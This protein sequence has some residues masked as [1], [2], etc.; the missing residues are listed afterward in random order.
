MS[1]ASS[2]GGA[3]GA[4]GVGIEGRITAWV[5]CHVLARRTVVEFDVAGVPVSVG[6]QTSHG[7]DDVGVVLDDGGYVLIQSKKKLTR[8][9]LDD[10]DLADAL[11]QVVAVFRDGL[12]VGHESS[13]IR[14]VDPVRDRLVILTDQDAPPTVREDMAQVVSRL[15]HLPATEPFDGVA[16]N[17]GQATALRVLLE[18]LR[19]EWS[20]HPA[21]AK[22]KGKTKGVAAPV[23]GS[24]TAAGC[25]HVPG[26]T[27]TDDEL[28]A[29]FRVLRVCAVGLSAGQPERRAA[30]TLAGPLL[31]VP[32]VAPQ[33]FERLAGL[34]QM[35]AEA[36]QWRGRDALKQQLRSWGLELAV[37][38]DVL[39]DVQRLKDL[40]G[41]ALELDSGHI[42][43]PGGSRFHLQRDVVAVL[44]AAAA[45][46]EALAVVG[47]AG[48]GKTA[49]VAQLAQQFRTT[50]GDVVYLTAETLAGTG[51]D[52]RVTLGLNHDLQQVLSGWEGPGHGLLIIDGL[53]GARLAEPSVWLR[54]LVAHLQQSRWH[55]VASMRMFD[56][57]RGRAWQR[58]FPGAAPDLN[59]AVAGLPDVRHVLV[60][61]LNDAEITLA[62]GAHA[63]LAKLVDVTSAAPGFTGLIRNMFNLAIAAD[64]LADPDV[65]IARV[66]GAASQRDLLRAYWQRRVTDYARAG[67]LHQLAARM[68]Q[69]RRLRVPNP[70][71]VVDSAGQKVLE[72][73]LRDGVLRTEP[74]AVGPDPVAFAHT[75][76]FDHAV[77]ELILSDGDDPENLAAVLEQDP[78]LAIVARPS[79]DMHLR[80][81]W[82]ADRSAFFRLALQLATDHPSA[83]AAAA[84]VMVEG[85][86]SEQDLEPL[87]QACL[88]GPAQTTAR[89]FAARQLGAALM[90]PG[91]LAAVGAAAAGPV[92]S[93]AAQLARTARDRDDVGLA[94]VARVLVNRARTAAGDGGPGA[95]DRAE[96][97]LAVMATALA[98]PE[99]G[100]RQSLAASIADALADAAALDPAGVEA[101]VTEICSKQAMAAWGPAVV[102]GLARRVT[103]LAALAP[104]A[105][106]VL[107]ETLWGFRDP[108]PEES[109]PLGRSSILSY[110]STRGGE[111]AMAQF[112]IGVH[113]PELLAADPVFAA[114]IY[115]AAMQAITPTADPWTVPTEPDS[116]DG[117]PTAAPA[118]PQLPQV[119]EGDALEWLGDH[120]TLARMTGQLAD[121]LLLLADPAAPGHD[122]DA[123]TEIINVLTGLRDA[124]AWNVLLDRGSDAPAT[125]GVALAALLPGG[126]LLAHPHTAEAAARLLATVRDLVDDDLHAAIEVQILADRSGFHGPASTQAVAWR[127]GMLLGVLRRDK[128]TDIEARQILDDYDAS[129]HAAPAPTPRGGPGLGARALDPS[130]LP[131]LLGRPTAEPGPADAIDQA[132]S[133]VFDPDPAGAS[134]ARWQLADA[135]TA[136]ADKLGNNIAATVTEDE[137]L[138]QAAVRAAAVLADDAAMAIDTALAER[139][140]TVL[141]A[142][143]GQAAS[144][145]PPPGW[146]LAKTVEGMAALLAIESTPHR[147][148]LSSALEVLS[149]M[150]DGAVQEAAAG[151][152]P[153]RWPDLQTR[154]T[155]VI[156]YL[157][158]TEGDAQAAWLNQLAAI[159]INDPAAGDAA[160][161]DLA[162]GEPWTLLSREPESGSPS[163]S[164]SANRPLR[165]AVELAVW[166]TVAAQQPQASATAKAWLSHPADHPVR[167]ERACV[168]LMDYFKLSGATAP[169]RRALADAFALAALPL[170]AARQA[171]ADYQAQ[172]A[173]PGASE[174][175]R[176]VLDVAVAVARAIHLTS[177][178]STAFTRGGL[179]DRDGQEPTAQ[180][181][182]RLAQDRQV[183]ADLAFPVL[184]QLGG[185][186]HPRV[187]EDTVRTLMHLASADP[188]RA[189]LAA[190]DAI[191]ASP[192]YHQEP[193]AEETVVELVERYLSDF[194]AVTVG[195]PDAGNALRQIIDRLV[196]AGWDRVI[197]LSQ[198]MSE[199]FR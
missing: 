18:H 80:D 181:L 184:E 76:L 90:A 128:L 183:F 173:E 129:G 98:S 123:A 168:D 6:G 11:R 96:A 105:V 190:R 120:E 170:P 164:I 74:A 122:S 141:L 58:L 5:A 52:A 156:E 47:E 102:H 158:A 100:E 163:G 9:E 3:G 25:G 127:T 85:G 185:V 121:R 104:R 83:A 61:P 152:T 31:S 176:P 84:A 149:Q 57:Q 43:I 63:G 192:G 103:D 193:R 177:G 23:T 135:F 154:R 194:R 101:A 99:P 95:A 162:G 114:R 55:V 131:G 196:D 126:R 92:S 22:P 180:D 29:L 159:A 169:G 178:E 195:Q 79:I 155:K 143:A 62:T 32:A 198:T 113:F 75:V 133:K 151:A 30:E 175:L 27:P 150:P 134:E 12:R 97:A 157:R 72:D 59:R 42:T 60:A 188:L 8:S 179:Q 165:Q 119:V 48:A 172:P 20:A 94:V 138:L 110:S 130:L 15:A 118:A 78:D 81:W 35:L 39:V 108:N 26:D 40:T 89:T 67:V 160:L 41:A 93:L 136:A 36:Q 51:A 68:L 49:A 137:R 174:R 2:T 45:A 112:E 153:I 171:W 140:A 116:P 146:M 38:P 73:L 7:V 64:L 53:D 144:Q 166:L 71:A 145:S 1:S 33:L 167:A 115:L 46:P 69:I 88:T 86:L 197:S 56:L 182:D 70:Q 186:G 13:L 50:G 111:M 16:R 24:Q 10:S 106:L 17:K 139:L 54:E 44:A 87:A 125:A 191:V 77:N 107:A 21:P 91:L 37:E 124:A 199:V 4:S 14:P 117:D 66:G 148:Q 65:D 187:A 142:C 189:L 28:R 34:G 132:L 109:V 19:R 161:A 82:S 147:A